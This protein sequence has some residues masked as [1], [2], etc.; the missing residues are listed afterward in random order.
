MEA[1][2]TI[3]GHVGGEVEYW[4]A[5]ETWA[6][7]K[8]RV[9]CT[10]R[11]WKAGEWVDSE[12][13]W[14]GVTCSRALAEHVKSSI[15]KGDPV[16]VVGRLRTKRWQD[17]NGVEQQRISIEATTVGHD[18]TRGTSIFRRVNRPAEEPVKLG[19]PLAAV[20]RQD[21]EDD[22]SVLDRAAMAVA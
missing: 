15:G 20:E 5:K 7:A 6:Y 18:L 22:E 16:I 12:T 3:T 17:T 14:L 1:L 10:P 4:L 8:F 2:V 9:A 13:T 11:T 21:G 19:E